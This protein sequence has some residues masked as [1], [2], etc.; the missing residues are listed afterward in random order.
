MGVLKTVV[1]AI[2]GTMPRQLQADVSRVPLKP[3]NADGVGLGATARAIFL[4]DVY[5]QF[6]GI[7]LLAVP[8]YTVR[9][10]VLTA[11]TVIVSDTTL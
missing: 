10:V 9:V 4:P 6:D 2:D 11:L 1:L 5:T 3:E 7:G 8:E